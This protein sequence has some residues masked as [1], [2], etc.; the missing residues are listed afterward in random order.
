MQRH[1]KA[2]EPLPL[3]GEGAEGADNVKSTA[4]EKTRETEKS[5]ELNKK[6]QKA[7]PDAEQE[8]AK[9]KGAQDAATLAG[10]S[11]APKQESGTNTESTASQKA[12]AGSTDPLPPL[13]TILHMP[14]PESQEERNSQKPPHLQTPPYV[15]HFDTYTLVQQ[16][17]AGDFTA[18]QS[19]TAMKA[20]RA[21]LAHNLEV[22]KAGLVSKSDVEN[23]SYVF[24]GT[25]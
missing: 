7:E 10:D 4:A 13:D 8:K 21:L 20:V 12:A 17:M 6:A 14:P 22:A 25:Q 16:V 1:G 2:V 11:N 24:A 9:A 18:A 23:V 19:I 3:N 5:K 15:H